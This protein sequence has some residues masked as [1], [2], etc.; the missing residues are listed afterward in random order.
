[1]SIIRLILLAIAVWLAFRIY[2]NWKRSA[3]PLAEPPPPSRI[4]TMVPCD[5]CGLHIP[6]SEAVRTL[7][8]T[9]CSDEHRRQHLG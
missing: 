2:R 3:P 6:D 4:G 7:D 9:Y 8:H 5:L 1:M